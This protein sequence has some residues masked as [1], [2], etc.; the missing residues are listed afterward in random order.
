MIV[1]FTSDNGGERFSDTWPFTGMKTQLLERGLR[2]PAIT[3]WPARD[4]QGRTTDQ[5]A[6]SMDW[7]PTLLAAAGTTP[8]PAY[9]PD[10]M[11]LLPFLAQNAL[12]V[13]RAD[14]IGE[15]GTEAAITSSG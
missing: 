14:R 6:I 8:D 9:P 15:Q 5:V 13:P 11:D 10:G 3:S 7:L 2:I 12:P 1:I 4:S